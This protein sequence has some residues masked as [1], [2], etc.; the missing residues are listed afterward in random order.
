MSNGRLSPSTDPC[1]TPPVFTAVVGFPCGGFEPGSVKYFR[2]AWIYG[3]IVDVAIAIKHSCPRFSCIDRQVDAAAFSVLACVPRP[4][5]EI[6]PVRC[7]GINCQPIRGV[8][9]L[10]H[11]YPPPVFRSISRFVNRAI[12]IS[13]YAP[14]LGTTGHQHVECSPGIPHNS[15]GKRFFLRDASVFQLPALAPVD[16]LVYS[17]PEGGNIKHARTRRTRRIQ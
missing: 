12:T 10:R 13:S 3:D 14:I 16:A 17:A 1:Q 9:P 7:A 6:K 5:C 4:R 8:A 11:R 2:V 15:P